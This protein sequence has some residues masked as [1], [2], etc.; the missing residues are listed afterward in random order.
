MA[1]IDADRREIMLVHLL[2]LAADKTHQ[3]MELTENFLRSQRIADNAIDKPTPYW[4]YAAGCQARLPVQVPISE[5][6][7]QLKFGFVGQPD[8][9]DI[10]IGLEL[11]EFAAW[12]GLLEKVVDINPQVFTGNPA[13]QFTRG[14][15]LIQ[16]VIAVG[17]QVAGLFLQRFFLVALDC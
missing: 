16:N 17:H 8:V 5:A 7:F 14:F 9:K 2:E 1:D 13:L 15:D 4:R 12:I 11:S 10:F 3:R 6:L